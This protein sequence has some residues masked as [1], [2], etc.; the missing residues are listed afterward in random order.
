METISLCCAYRPSDLRGRI[1]YIH[2][3]EFARMKKFSTYVKEWNRDYRHYICISITLL[4]LAAGFLFPNSLPRL[5]ET[6]RDLALSIAYYFC[7]LIIPE[8]NPIHPSV[9]NMQAWQFRPELWEPIQIFPY[10]FEEFKILFK[11]FWQLLFTKGN[12][13]LYFGS[14]GDL[15]YYL[16]RSLLIVLPFFMILIIRLNKYKNKYCADRKKKSKQLIRFENQLFRK[17][18]PCIAWFKGF[19][20]FVKNNQRYWKGWFALWMLHFNLISIV[21]AFISYYFYFSASWE[22]RSLYVQALKLLRDLT[23]MIRFV[24]TLMWICAGMW[25]YNYICRSMAFTRLYHAESCNRAFLKDRGIVTTVYGEMGIGKTQMI[26]SM[27]LSAEIEQF[28]MAFDILVEK[29]TQFPNFT[30]QLFRDELKK[31]IDNRNIVDLPTCRKWVQRCRVFFERITSIYTADEYREKR[32]KYKL[33][34]NDYTFGYDYTHYRTTYKDELKITHLFDAL[35]DYACAYLVFTVKT[36][37]LF[38]NYSIRV[39]SILRDIGNM[40]ERDNDFLHRDPEY[41]EAYSHHAHIIDIDMLRLGRKIIKDNPKARRLSF[42]V[43]VIT[44]IDK[45]FKNMQELKE[46]KINSSETN[47]RNDLHDAC[48]MMI[49]HANVIAN[50]VFVRVIA[51]LQRPEAWGA[52]GR[53]LGEVIYITEKSDL[54]PALPFFSPYWFCQGVFSFVKSKWTDFK[55]AYDVNRSDSTLFTYLCQ[56]TVSKINNHYDKVEGQ[57]GLQTLKL[58]IQS[59]RLDGNV[60]KEKWRLIMKKDRSRRY[61][62]SC[63]E[64]VFESYTPNTM[65]IDDFICYA[66]EVGTQ[67][68]NELQNSYFQNDIMKMKLLNSTT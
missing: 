21:I 67:E 60:K 51:D 19:V 31:Q 16:S 35:E 22:F 34:R 56:N 11:E 10:T 53:E 5:A 48:L 47:Q 15:L 41:Q 6:F 9:T 62:T 46:V 30:W 33:I 52:G 45:E 25:L 27:A 18:Y 14:I 40:P 2:L 17:I 13:L 7:E 20:S 3:E 44:E 65:H 32:E 42:G 66:G 49:R 26:T 59:G 57:F 63:L 58:E 64:A 1:H 38:S 23:P 12:F 39:D 4:S 36:T 29:S 55:N 24:P 28:D 68:E 43:F 54:A 37:L 61:R 50:R 8:R